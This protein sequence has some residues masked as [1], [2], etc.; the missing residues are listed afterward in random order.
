MKINTNQSLWH[1]LNVDV[2][3]RYDAA[4]NN[5]EKHAFI[6]SE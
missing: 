2:T 4:D 5:S 1:Y 3:K 6:E